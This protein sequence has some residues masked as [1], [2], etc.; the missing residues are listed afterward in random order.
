[1]NYDI[2][3]VF[4]TGLLH[5]FIQKQKLEKLERIISF[6]ALSRLSDSNL[7]QNAC[8]IINERL[9]PIKAANPQG[10]WDDWIKTA[11]FER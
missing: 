8:N 9:K 2:H 6:L 4:S 7:F 5:Y 10:K 3:C 11:Y 1:M